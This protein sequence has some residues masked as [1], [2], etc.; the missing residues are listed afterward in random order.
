[1]LTGEAQHVLKKHEGRTVMR[2]FRTSLLPLSFLVPLEIARAYA[3]AFLPR[4]S[5]VSAKA[6]APPNRVPSD[7][8]TNSAKAMSTQFYDTQ[9]TTVDYQ[10]LFTK[11]DS[12]ALLEHKTTT[13][14][15]AMT[16]NGFASWKI[17]QFVLGDGFPRPEGW[18]DK[19]V[20]MFTEEIVTSPPGP[21]KYKLKKEYLQ[22]LQVEYQVLGTLDRK[23]PKYDKD[24][25]DALRRIADAIETKH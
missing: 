17:A 24:E 3:E 14:A 7:Q 11:R 18:E 19:D 22:F 21:Q 9:L 8:S 25:V 23:P 12:E 10:I 4:S 6:P 1:V 13:V 20:E 5:I 16:G 15:T 2:P